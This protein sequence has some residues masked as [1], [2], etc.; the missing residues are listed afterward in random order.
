MFGK[1]EKKGQLAEET[2][3]QDNAGGKKGE[4]ELSEKE[5][6]K[7]RALEEKLQRKEKKLKMKE[8]AKAAKAANAREKGKGTE[9]TEK[10][11]DSRDNNK[12]IETKTLFSIRFKVAFIMVVSVIVAVA[13]NYVYLTSMSEEALITNTESTLCDIAR[14][15]GSYIDQTIQKYQ[16]TM[17]YLNNSENITIFEVNAGDKFEN[18][19]IAMLTKFMQKN[20]D[21]ESISFVS[22]SSK[23]ILAST[24]DSLVGKDCSS[25]AF[26]N[27]IL[28]NN[29][30]AQS[31]IFVDESSGEPV[32]SIGVP[33]AKYK[34]TTLSGVMF[35]NIKASLL[36]DAV[37]GIKI[38]NEESSYAC[39]LDSNGNYIYHPDASLIGTKT[40]DE[41]ILNVVERIQAG[42]TP[43]PT[44]TLD[45]EGNYITYNVSALN[46]WIL[47][48]SVAKS[49]VL[50]PV[51]QMSSKAFGISVFLLI[52]L[53]G[54][55]FVFAVSIT[56]PL[57]KLTK[58]VRKIS[59][60]DLAPHSKYAY[61]SKKKDETGEISRA[62]ER[63]RGTFQGMMGE[64]SAIS[65][66]ITEDANRLNQIANVVT[67]H[68]DNNFAT[69]EQLSAGMQET[70]ASTDVISDD[71]VKIETYTAAINERA[72]DGV[73][74]SEE[75]MK[76]T[77][78]MKEN[79][80][81]ASAT[82]KQMYE[83]V[84]NE[85]Q[86]AIERSKAVSR[87]DEL[88]NAIKEIAGQTSLLSLNASIEAAR[89]GEAGRG[90]S[91]VASEIGKLA[92][93]SSQTVG[94]ITSIVQ[95][96]TL[97]V[98]DMTKSLTKTLDFLENKVLGDYEGFISISEKYATDASNIN[99][100][101]K[102]V[103]NSI[104]ELNNS[105]LKI[106]D[107]ITGINA[108]VAESTQ[109]VADVA[110]NNSDIVKLTRDTYQMAQT[111][112]GNAEALD[113][114]IGKFQL[115]K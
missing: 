54:L 32:I 31:D 80:L 114:I 24:D 33:Q 113:A 83:A 53:A 27:Y 74:L 48:I 37:A 88:A 52:V 91:V 59:D 75:I 84:R 16:A 61:L 82:T 4:K 11:S 77:V 51:T 30:P 101:M 102:E 22:A 62:V 18:E 86:N 115:D 97:A 100:T 110:N 23:T 103:D 5:E 12:K 73:R 68:A 34:D 56:A 28:E 25:E 111:T 39:L 29:L 15:Q 21:L 58:V 107:A 79:T 104:D 57:K 36:S 40:T 46:H 63:M 17:T 87:I 70:S 69:T 109:G 64:L 50:E 71:V 42:E 67:D 92:E 89:A 19:I 41:L 96:V 7:K 44:V 94:N 13:V 95:E 26:V 45:E 43:E 93:Q 76:R 60:L 105:I 6:K 108:S 2:V 106:S 72:T 81:E 99:Q 112:L 98:N 66:S 3:M 55:G 47:P 10:G 49:D 90:F 78:E 85:T 65:A 9:K 8:E 1:E 35:V 38:N 14:A 20:Q